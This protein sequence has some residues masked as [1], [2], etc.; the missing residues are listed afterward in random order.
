[1]KDRVGFRRTVGGA[2]TWIGSGYLRVNALAGLPG[3]LGLTTDLP[4]SALAGR[5]SPTGRRTEFQGDIA[6]PLAR[7]RPISCCI[8]IR[9]RSPCSRS[10]CPSSS[11]SGAAVRRSASLEPSD[12]AAS[13]QMAVVKIIRTAPSQRGNEFPVPSFPHYLSKRPDMIGSSEIPQ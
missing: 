8:L 3:A 7:L 2:K 10:W 13:R 9:T 4:R 1:M 12:Y 5:N 6:L 11:P